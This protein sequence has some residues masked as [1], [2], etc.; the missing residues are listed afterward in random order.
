MSDEAELDEYDVAVVVFCRTTGVDEADAENGAQLA[1]RNAI[2]GGQRVR[3]LPM[4]IPLPDHL[5]E[6]GFT[7]PVQVAGVSGL[8][9][10]GGQ[11]IRLRA[12]AEPYQNAGMG[13]PRKKDQ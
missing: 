11:G 7:D 12:T 8:R 5:I 2:A 1:V 10:V 4:L 3:A 13:G 9:Y 6:R